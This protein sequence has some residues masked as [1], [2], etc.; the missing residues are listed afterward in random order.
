MFKII[1]YDLDDRRDA[2]EEFE[3]WQEA[4]TRFNML[5]SLRIAGER[6]MQLEF[7]GVIP[8]EFR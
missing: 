4:R 2:V 3:D 8:H 7:R 1:Y 6:I 5:Q